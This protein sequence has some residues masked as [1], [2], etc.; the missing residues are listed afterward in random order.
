MS[1]REKSWSVGGPLRLGL[2]SL[3]VLV[4]G[5]GTWGVTTT[6][7]GAVVASGQV[8]V[9]RNRQAI[10]H[11]DGG[12]VAE[13][14]VDEGDRVD[15]AQVLVRLDPSELETELAVVQA[16]LAEVQARR[17]RLEAERDGREELS[18]G[19]EL[20]ALAETDPEIADLV[21][22][23]Q[24]LF[25]ARAETAEQ[26]L[27]QLRGR[28]TQISAQVQA[29]QAQQEALVGQVALVEEELERR[30][31][32]LDSG[33]GTR[34]PVVRLRQELVQLQ[35]SAGEVVAGQAEA[36][37]RIIETELEILQLQT[38]RREQA[39]ALLRETR[40]AEQELTERANSLATRIARMELRAPVPGHIHGL[41]IFGSGSVLRPADPFAYLVPEG[42]PLVISARVPAIDV[43][44]VY[45]GQDV[46][47]VFPAFNQ[48]E[49]SEITGLVSQ[50]SADAFVDDVSG[51][52]FY[53][54]EI[55]LPEDQA[56][57]LGGRVLV[58][59]MPVD[60]FIRTEDRTPMSYLLEPFMA[61]FGR[62]LRES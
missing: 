40:V 36:A 37:E 30:Q 29:L 54:A 39:I 23:Q 38:E 47:L 16:N 45:T 5:F 14:L 57:L 46:T 26:A 62:A 3:L 44:Q 1:A 12:L 55:T 19:P 25:A 32:L 58:P 41:T 11:P 59:G 13:L 33:S 60:A 48:N 35:G 6:L 9:D 50:V 4:G 28:I 15:A 43:D 27:E 20:R 22:G 18:F 42:R 49:L 51:S 34:E 56:A 31:A 8:E 2:V 24:Y 53:R 61:Y 10:Q 52:S 17:A 21:A 7:S